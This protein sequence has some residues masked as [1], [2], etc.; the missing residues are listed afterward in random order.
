[1]VTQKNFL[2]FTEAS[3]A[4]KLKWYQGILGLPM[5]FIFLDLAVV[6]IQISAHK[7]A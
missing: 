6:F 1:M 4:E 2:D 3:K 7:T 5:Q